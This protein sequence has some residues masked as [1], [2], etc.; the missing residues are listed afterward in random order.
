[1][2]IL[3][4]LIINYILCVFSL[5]EKCRAL[6]I[7]GG[8]DR[9]A[10][11]AG[12]IIGLINSLPADESQW[13]VVTGVGTGALNALIVSQFSIGK[14]N[15]LTQALLEFWGNFTY[16]KIYKDWDGWYIEAFRSKSGLYNSSPMNDTIKSL[17][18][19]NFERFLG[20]GTTDLI[21]GNYVFFNSTTQSKD[22]MLLG[23]YASASDYGYLPIVEYNEFKL[24]SGHIKFATDILHAVNACYELGYAQKDIILDIV[25][26]SGKSIEVVDT[27]QYRTLQFL[28]R[29][30]EITS[31]YSAM[32]AILN[33]GIDFPEVTVRS[34]VYPQ[35]HLPYSFYLYDY[36]HKENE[37][38]L[39]EGQK[40]AIN[41]LDFIV[42]S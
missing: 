16:K 1:M 15:F 6:S 18:S 12:A 14:E 10:Y 33:L 20:V 32:Q 9:G 36:S 17:G 37:K 38:M 4:I 34:I 26:T 27:T 2:W 24:V 30:W 3:V 31:F 11:E 23:I 22:A 21:S 7:G 28:T 39:I 25:L 5:P 19:Q 41:S 13:K 42:S 29:Y 40:D 35:S 8:T